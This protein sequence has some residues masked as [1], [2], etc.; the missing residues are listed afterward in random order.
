[1]YSRNG[2]TRPPTVRGLGTPRTPSYHR[3]RVEV[4]PGYSGHAI[5]DGEEHPLGSERSPAEHTSD[6]PPSTDRQGPR[7]LPRE[8]IPEPYFNDLPRVSDAGMSI[9]RTAPRPES[10]ARL[11]EVGLPEAE[12]FETIRITDGDTPSSSTRPGFGLL[13]PSHF[14]V[15]H[16]LGFEELFLLGLMLFLLLEARENGEKGDLEETLILLGALLLA[17]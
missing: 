6:L 14:P 13:D 5:I 2:D 9:H 10:D 7:S 1:M 12:S 3:R 11:S 16:G 17:G 4:P 8:P 15:G